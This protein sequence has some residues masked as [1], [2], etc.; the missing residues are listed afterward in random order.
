[1]NELLNNQLTRPY[2][3][4]ELT[5]G[6]Y[7]VRAETEHALEWDAEAD[8]WIKA[9]D[10]KKAVAWGVFDPDFG[11]IATEHITFPARW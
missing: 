2:Q 1:M 9:T 5:R 7:G 11:W 3:G 4:S 8:G 6:D 10:P